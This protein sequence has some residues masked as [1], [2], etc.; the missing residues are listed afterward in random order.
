MSDLKITAII[1]LDLQDL[2][3]ISML[4]EVHS[5]I[6]RPSGFHSDHTSR[7]PPAAWR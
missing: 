6:P 3:I 5:A 1:K 4:G 7:F 2:Y